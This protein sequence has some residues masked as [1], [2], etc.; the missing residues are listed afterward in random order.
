MHY[1]AKLPPPQSAKSVEA[2]VA[3]VRR[4]V[5][6]GEEVDARQKL[7]LDRI[8]KRLQ[9]SGQ[10]RKLQTDGGTLP[11]RVAEPMWAVGDRG[12]DAGYPAPPAQIRTCPIKAYGSIVS[13]LV[14]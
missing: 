14:V 12:M 10:R 8:V 1:D 7:L 6:H 9:A 2:P 13:H 5:N 3:S 11:H 4:D